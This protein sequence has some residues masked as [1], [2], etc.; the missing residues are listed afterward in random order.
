MAAAPCAG[1]VCSFELGESG[2]SPSP[3]RCRG[4]CGSRPR[5]SS[6]T[7]SATSRPGTTASVIGSSGTPT[8]PWRQRL[9]GGL[10]GYDRLDRRSSTVPPVDGARAR[11]PPRAARAGR[12]RPRRRRRRARRGARRGRRRASRSAPFGLDR[13]RRES[14]S[15]ALA[16]LGRGR[17][18]RGSG[19]TLRPTMASTSSA[20]VSVVGST[21]LEDQ[22]AAAQ[23]RHP[24]G[25]G[26]GLARACG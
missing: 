20:S 4:P 6:A 11:A 22:R 12:C 21:P 10:P 16:A 9:R 24:V 2:A 26:P 14:D 8:A 18:L 17:P 23:D 7:C 13:R 1:R 5:S 25:D 3:S 15:T 19:G